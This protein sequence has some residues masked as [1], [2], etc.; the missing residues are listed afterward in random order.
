MAYMGVGYS[1]YEYSTCPKCGSG[2]W[3]GCCENRDCE[4]HWHPYDENEEENDG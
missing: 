4:Y 2:M 1:G 3:N